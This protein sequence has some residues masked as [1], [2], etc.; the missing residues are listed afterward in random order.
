M[1]LASTASGPASPGETGMASRHMGMAEYPGFPMHIKTKSQCPV[2]E[3][4]RP[5]PV[6]Q[7]SQSIEDLCAERAVV[8]E[9]WDY[10][11]WGPGQ[12]NFMRVVGKLGKGRRAVAKEPPT[13]N[14]R[15]APPRIV[16]TVDTTSFHLVHASAP[17]PPTWA[18]PWQRRGSAGA[19]GCPTASRFRWF[20]AVA[21]VHPRPH[22]APVHAAVLLFHI[23]LLG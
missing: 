5:L 12:G 19:R 3:L 20:R 9:Y 4:P 1:L 7:P 8:G 10:P 15:L 21:G 17:L 14:A 2:S 13:P 23:H 11:G 18:G 6:P 22:T 16:K